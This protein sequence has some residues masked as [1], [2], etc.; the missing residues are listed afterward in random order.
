MVILYPIS[1]DVQLQ[2]PAFRTTQRSTRL[3]AMGYV[4]AT[5]TYKLFDLGFKQSTA[6]VDYMVSTGYM[7]IITLYVGANGGI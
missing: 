4:A 3:L 2:L 1:G 5:R 6:N 7:S